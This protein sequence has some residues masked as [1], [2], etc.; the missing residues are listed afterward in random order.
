APTLSSTES[1]G[2][3]AAAGTYSGNYRYAGAVDPNYTI[4]YVAGDL[5]VN[6]ALLTITANGQTITYGATVPGTM[7]SYSGFVNGDSSSSLSTAPTLSSTE[8][9]GQT[10]A[11]GTYSGNYRY[12]GAV[13]PN[14][15]ISYVAGDLLVNPA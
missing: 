2:Q 3:T 14:Y 4:S 10:A 12:A 11:A 8:S 1:L 13:D 7:A 9:L 6:P 15:T 5:L